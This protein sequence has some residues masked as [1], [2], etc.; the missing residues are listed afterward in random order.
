MSYVPAKVCSFRDFTAMQIQIWVAGLDA[1]SLVGGL[2]DARLRLLP[3]ADLADARPQVPLLIV[4]AD[5]LG[6]LSSRDLEAAVLHDPKLLTAI[7]QAVREVDRCRLVNLGCVSPP[8]L[9]AWC[10]GN[11]EPSSVDTDACFDLPDPYDALVALELLNGHP[12]YLRIYQELESHPLA[13]ALDGRFPDLNCLERYRKAANLQALLVARDKRVTLKRELVELARICNPI[14]SQELDEFA[15]AEVLE[16][17]RVRLCQ[18][19]ELQVR[20]KE[21]RISLQLQ[22]LDIEQSFRRLAL[23]QDLVA[24]AS[25]ASKRVQELLAQAFN[26]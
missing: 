22:Q 21:L 11:C 2:V 1:S 17:L 12:E 15:L 6:W 13:A 10:L 9:V 4:Y 18:A 16:F 14:Y 19:E 8:A 23:L 26:V 20:C 7:F 24:S 3:L 25:Y 5:P